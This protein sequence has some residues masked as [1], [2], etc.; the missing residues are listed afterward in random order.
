MLAI[1]ARQL[2]LEWKCLAIYFKAN[3]IVIN[4]GIYIAPL[5]VIFN[6]AHDAA[7]FRV[8]HKL[9]DVIVDKLIQCVTKNIT[10][11]RVC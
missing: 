6:V 7:R 2:Q 3:N 11:S 8:L 10:R 1:Y 5:A 4:V 9:V